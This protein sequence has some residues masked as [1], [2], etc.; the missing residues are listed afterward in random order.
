M[1]VSNLC[2]LS[3]ELN[4]QR[5]QAREDLKGLEET[6]VSVRLKLCQVFIPEEA[7]NVLRENGQ[8]LDFNVKQSLEKYCSRV[9]HTPLCTIWVPLSINQLESPTSCLIG[10]H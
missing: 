3:R 10:G 1:L 8:I 9:P 6:V 7:E 5:E 4:E 2:F